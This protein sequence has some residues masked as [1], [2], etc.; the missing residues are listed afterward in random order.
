MLWDRFT[1]RNNTIVHTLL[2]YRTGHIEIVWRMVLAIPWEL[3]LGSWPGIERT[4]AIHHKYAVMTI[5]MRTYH[6]K[7]TKQNLAYGAITWWILVALAKMQNCTSSS[8]NFRLQS[9]S[10]FQ[11]FSVFFSSV[12]FQFLVEVPVPLSSLSYS[13]VE[14]WCCS[15]VPLNYNIYTYIV[16]HVMRCSVS[17]TCS[18]TYLTTASTMS[19]H[20][21]SQ[22]S[23]QM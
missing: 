12:G 4:L 14:R 15:W 8:S 22:L 9:F 17:R 16:M 11:F 13:S 6:F 21:T 10:F 18:R 5:H 2:W 1:W 20:T 3:S 19:R 23:Y 7:R